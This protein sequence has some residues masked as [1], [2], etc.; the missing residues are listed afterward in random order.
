MCPASLDEPLL[1]YKVVV[2]FGGRV[3]FVVD[4]AVR[5]VNVVHLTEGER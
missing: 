5:I 3:A 2:F 1:V 4:V